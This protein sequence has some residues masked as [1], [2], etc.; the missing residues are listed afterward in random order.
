MTSYKTYWEVP[1]KER[2]L[3]VEDDIA[4]FCR[5]DLAEAGYVYPKSPKVLPEE[6]PTLPTRTV[7]RP[8]IDQYDR[9][10]VAFETMA[11]A[12]AFLKLSALKVDRDYRTDV[13]YTKV[14][15][16]MSITPTEVVCEVDLEGL[17]QTLTEAKSN[18]DANRDARATYDK[19]LRTCDDLVESVRQDW[20][21]RIGHEE[22][23]ERVRTTFAE[24]LEIANDDA[25]VATRFLLK[26]HNR[27]VAIEALGD[28]LVLE[29][30]VATEECR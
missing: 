8:Q 21:E 19:D 4:Q 17:R 15:A 13:E 5:V 7:Y 1:E 2:H 26:K 9:L 20:R 29:D 24:F 27:E 28:A 3:L 25:E 23:L 16:G 22:M 11:D 14:I 6:K 12:E 30:A 18:S 10:G